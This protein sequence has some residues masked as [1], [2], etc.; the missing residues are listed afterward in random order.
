[1][2]LLLFAA[3][4]AEAL[5]ARDLCRE[6][7]L[8]ATLARPGLLLAR[9]LGEASAVRDDLARVLPPF[10]AAL[11]GLPARLPRLWTS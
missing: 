4:V 10:R 5:A 6:L 9:W 7:G 2:G 11:L 3:P 1:M 8:D